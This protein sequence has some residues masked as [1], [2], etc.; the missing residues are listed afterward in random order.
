MAQ[1]PTGDDVIVTG[2]LACVQCHQT[3]PIAEE[4]LHTVS[5]REI[6]ATYPLMEE[7]ARKV[8]RIYDYFIDKFAAILG[9]SPV[10]T[11]AEYL[12]RLELVPG[13][14]ILDVG[15][16]TGT[17]LSYLWLKTINAQMFGLDLSIEMLRQCQ[18]KLGKMNAQAELFLGFAERLPFQDNTFDVVFHAG[19]INEFKDQRAALEEIIRVAKPGTRIVIVDEWLTAENL[20]QPIGQ[21]LLEVFPTV[22]RVTAPPVD[23]VPHEMQEKRVDAIWRG[24]GYCLQFRKPL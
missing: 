14:K 22:S 11:R 3:Y 19:S 9:M 2:Q 8:V 18:R 23:S 21:R 12:E 24:Y 15:V 4:I 1:Q 20:K 7:H 13:A 5:H 17:E 10:D 16:G 6:V